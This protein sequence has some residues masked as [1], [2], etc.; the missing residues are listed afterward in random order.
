MQQLFDSCHVVQ[1][2]D[3]FFIN[4]FFFVSS[5]SFDYW[6]K[7]FTALKFFIKSLISIIVDRLYHLFFH[8]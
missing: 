8:L 2:I 6:F 7:Q 1:L 4:C 3:P 5:L